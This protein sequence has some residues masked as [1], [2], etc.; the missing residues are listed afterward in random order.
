MG[1]GTFDQSDRRP[2]APAEAIAEL[3]DKLHPR[4]AA[5]DHHNAM[6]RLLARALAH[7]WNP[8]HSRRMSLRRIEIMGYAPKGCAGRAATCGTSALVVASGSVFPLKL[9][10]DIGIGVAAD[11]FPVLD[12]VPGLSTNGRTVFPGLAG[13]IHGG[14]SCARGRAILIKDLP[15]L[16]VS[17]LGDP[18]RREQS[19]AHQDLS[20]EPLHVAS[21][22]TVAAGCAIRFTH[23]RADDRRAR[24]PARP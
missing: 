14:G 13:V 5:A 18:K 19:A 23:R 6:Q 24:G 3:R 17:A 10:T 7:T 20:D 12:H 9:S 16:S 2:P 8:F 22:C 1:A 11:D 21:P 4:R 15:R